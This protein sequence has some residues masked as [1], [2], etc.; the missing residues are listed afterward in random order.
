M[1]LKKNSENPILS[2]N[3][4]NSWENLAVCNPGAWYEDGKFYL[5]YRAAGDDED[6]LI[7]FGLAVSDDGFT[8]K[9]VSDQPVFSP[10]SDGPDAG[11]VEDARIVKFDDY[12]Y[13][14]YAYR[15]FPPG[16][17]WTMAPDQVNVANHGQNAP[18]VVNKNI[19]NTGLAITKDFKSF[20]RL[21][22][23]TE[24]VL[25]DRDVILFP[26]KIN[27]K[28]ALL[29]RPKEWIGPDYGCKYP[30]IWLTLS[31]DMM[32]WDYSTSVMVIQGEEAWEEK[33][34][35]STPP[36]YT[37]DGWLTLY[38]GVDNKGIYRV[39]A[40]LLDLENPAKVLA[41]TKDFIMEPEF[42]YEN[43]GLYN[44]CV[45][46]TG[47]VIVDNTLYVYYGAADQYCGVATCKVDELVG[48]IKSNSRE[49]ANQ[50][51]VNA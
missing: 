35:G 14:T 11:C 40:M 8:F 39:G 15:P 10:S 43:E 16:Q 6:H 7:H 24:T 5:L 30:A 21:G 1:K 33:I 27:G 19:A 34:G 25:D 3:P 48:F 50:E 12:Y 46:P 42:D 47:N 28:Y 9:R 38:H 13:V 32:N 51:V 36:L 23:M 44:G 49:R 31:D 4:N 2:P 45:F 37:E 17:Y 26:E 29:N 41:K 20:K 18:A 22:R